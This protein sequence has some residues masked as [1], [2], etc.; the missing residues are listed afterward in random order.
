MVIVL[1]RRNVRDVRDKREKKIKNRK[2]INL[3]AYK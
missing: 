2:M 3:D 1:K